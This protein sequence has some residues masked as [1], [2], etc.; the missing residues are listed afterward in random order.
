M[1]GVTCVRESCLH[2]EG[3][4]SI[5]DS[6]QEL[7]DLLGDDEEVSRETNESQNSREEVD[8][9]ERASSSE[10]RR[11]L[12]EEGRRGNQLPLESP[13]AQNEEGRHVCCTPMCAHVSPGL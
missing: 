9:S 7:A 11:L 1:H 3:V 4:E 5:Q 13:G 10:Q 8:S 6:L 2:I 12:G